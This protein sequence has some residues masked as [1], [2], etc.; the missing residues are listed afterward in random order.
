[1]GEE[2]D[3]DMC[4]DLQEAIERYLDEHQEEIADKLIE[5][6]CDRFAESIEQE[7][8]WVELESGKDRL[9]IAMDSLSG[10]REIVT[11]ERVAEGI[12]HMIRRTLRH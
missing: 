4:L 11:G 5:I 8:T 9:S 10:E 3:N 12:G 1:M 7:R 6:F 2:K